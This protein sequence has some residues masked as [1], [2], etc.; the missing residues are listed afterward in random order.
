MAILALPLASPAYA[1]PT[2]PPHDP[3][4]SNI[5]DK[6]ATCLMEDATAPS[7]VPASLDDYLAAANK[8]PWQ[9]AGKVH[10]G[11]EEP[12]FPTSQLAATD[13]RE[14]AGRPRAACG[15]ARVDGESP[16]RCSAAL[17][18]LASVPP[19]PGSRDLGLAWSGH[20]GEV[21]L[22]LGHGPQWIG[23]VSGPVVAQVRPGCRLA[24]P[25]LSGQ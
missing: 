10:R 11:G 17:P 15:G 16:G 23:P 24:E 1:P 8:V 19:P 21:T 18:P 13:A 20:M 2:W 12:T 3:L 9:N 25:G 14:T 22:G 5:T 4:W 7:P 6:E